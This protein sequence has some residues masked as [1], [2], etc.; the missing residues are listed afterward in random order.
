MEEA[1]MTIRNILYD[2]LAYAVDQWLSARVENG[3]DD[4][5]LVELVV[6]AAYRAGWQDAE[7]GPPQPPGRHLS[8][9]R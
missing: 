4:R 7:A 3:L 1:A 5:A 2:F 6:S 8:V 9:V